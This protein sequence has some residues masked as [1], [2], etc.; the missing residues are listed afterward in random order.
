MSHLD[1]LKAYSIQKIMRC[2]IKFRGCKANQQY[3]FSSRC[4]WI[5]RSKT[6]SRCSGTV[7]LIWV[8]I[9]QLNVIF[10]TISALQ[11]TKV[12]RSLN[13]NTDRK[14]SSLN[15]TNM[16]QIICMNVKCKP[17]LKCVRG[18]LTWKSKVKSSVFSTENVFY[19]DEI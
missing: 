8:L 7:W 4:W 11:S 16:F 13:L 12:Q 2:N 17:Y 14:S 15:R 9:K 3:V 18:P 19:F 6:E 1:K 10:M 5:S